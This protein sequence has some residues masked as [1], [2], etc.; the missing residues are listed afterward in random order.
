[1][2]N[3]VVMKL[4]WNFPS[5]G[6]LNFSYL[7]N[8]WAERKRSRAELGLDKNSSAQAITMFPVCRWDAHKIRSWL[9]YQ[10]LLFFQIT[11]LQHHPTWPNGLRLHSSYQ[12]VPGSIPGEGFCIFFSKIIDFFINFKEV[13]WLCPKKRETKTIKNN[14]KNPQNRPGWW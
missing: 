4:S 10:E 11:S 12:K 8:F 5:R 14:S 3:L 13:L 7:A 1:M 9:K 2:G 6:N